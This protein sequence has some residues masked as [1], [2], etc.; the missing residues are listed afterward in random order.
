MIEANLSREL[1]AD[2]NR[3]A[4]ER[5]M[6]TLWQDLRYNARTRLK[7]RASPSTLKSNE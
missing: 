6:E 3:I 1:S 2:H 4:E 7:I 5:R